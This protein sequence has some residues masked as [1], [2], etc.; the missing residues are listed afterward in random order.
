MAS[1]RAKDTKPE[2]AVRRRLWA[3][4]YRYRTHYN[5]LTGKPD[6]VFVGPRIA[7]FIDGDFWHGNAW[8][9]RGLRSLEDLFPTNTDWWVAKIRRNME[10]DQEVTTALE[11]HGWT[12]LRFWESDVE[13][14]PDGV[15]NQIRG[16]IDDRVKNPRSADF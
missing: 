6:L 7:V 4:G 15:V 16:S 5:G 13:R 1:V 12:V 10:R 8:R 11:R 2:L 3:Q 14:D 9:L